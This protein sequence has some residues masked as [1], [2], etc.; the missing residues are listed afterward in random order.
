MAKSKLAQANE[1]IAEGVVEGYKKI[2]EGAVGRFCKIADRFVDHF[3]TKEGESV[4]DAK[5]RLAV[6]QKIREEASAAERK[7]HMTKQK[8]IAEK[9]RRKVQDTAEEGRKAGLE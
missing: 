6:E 5:I 1:K 9:N 3:L 8:E 7:Q 4:E 2:E